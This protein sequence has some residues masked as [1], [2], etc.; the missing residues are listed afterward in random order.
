MV[1]VRDRTYEALV[2]RARDYRE[3]DRLLR[4]V[5][6]E[7]GPETVIAR[8]ARKTGHVLTA[9]SQSF[10]RATLTLS[11]A[12]NG[13]SFLKE[14]RQEESYLPPGGDVTRFAYLSYCS[15]LL[16]AGW[17]EDR[18]DP[19]LY[20]LARAAFLL[21]RQDEDAARTARFFEVRLL[22]L[23]GLLPDLSACA[24]CGHKPGQDSRR[25]L[26]AP[27]P[28]RLLCADCARRNGETG[29][30]F[31]PGALLA[32]SH[33]AGDPLPRVAHLRLYQ[34]QQE[35]LEPALAAFLDYHLEY[36]G[37]ARAILKQLR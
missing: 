25:F 34:A 36:A 26:L 30:L 31:S 2:L 5:S 32:L 1:D 29:P 35:E 21:L 7:A 11:P 28:G 18:P 15:E 23:L 12:K 19:A 10:C 20:A 24:G 13:V 3:Q 17:P 4:I 37:R 6:A 27:R 16:L 14:G 8:G 22:E 9:C 33:L